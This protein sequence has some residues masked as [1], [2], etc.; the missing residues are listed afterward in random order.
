MSQL[1]QVRGSF[2][3]ISEFNP[4]RPATRAEIIKLNVHQKTAFQL[5]S[6]DRKAEAL[7]WEV[8]INAV[9]RLQGIRGSVT[10]A[11]K[12]L[13]SRA[14]D[15]DLQPY[16]LQALKT[17]AVGKNSLPS[18]STIFEKIS[19]YREQ[20]LDGL[21][22]QHKGRIRQE[23][24]WEG[25]ALELYSLPSKPDFSAVHR[26]LVAMG[27]KC[28]YDQV[29]DYLKALPATLGAMSP[30]RIGRD[31]YRQTEAKYIERC[32]D[33]LLPGDIYMADGYRADVYLAHPVTGDIWR[34]E[35]MHV[36]DLR[37]RVLVGYRIMAHEGSYD[38]MFG[39]AEIF[40]RW[41]HVP[42]LLYVDNGSGY[43]NRL[44]ELE[45]VSYYQRAGIQQV[46]HSIPRNPRG[47]GH[48]ERY[49]RTVKDRHL[50]LWRPEC[51]CGDD[52]A[53]EVLQQTVRDA[54][55]GRL[56]LP[57]VQ[58]FIAAYD[59]WI[60]EY[61]HDVHPEDKNLI[62]WDLWMQL[63][64]IPPHATVA[65]IARPAEKRTVL[66]GAVQ[67]NNRRYRCPDLIMWNH[68]EVMV[69]CDVL[70]DKTV[71]IRTLKGE[72]I[73]SANLV[74]KIGM[75]SDSLLQ[76]KRNAAEKAAIKRK[77]KQIAEIEARNGFVIDVDAITE[78]LL[79]ETIDVTPEP[80]NNTSIEIDLND[81]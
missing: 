81:I 63:Q 78:I 9:Q 29:K 57:T 2:V 7:Q 45:D 48:V 12:L 55:S 37:S 38:I 50:K 54:K 10:T 1:K 74:E 31:L 69:E 46:I 15:N 20:G 4:P 68:Q 27:L 33:N 39:W 51:Y 5:A 60:E 80:T 43:K 73:C 79:P 64:P 23:L 76:D 36:L 44:T 62:K 49:H 22:K 70:N 56:Q 21:I 19:A 17:V 41:N 53:P 24:G 18:R 58:E 30:A 65:Q 61:N 52:M 28:S 59:K 8:V 77:Q 25:F 13:L 66:K 72:F 16:V 26:R 32:T 42:P 47:K 11:V 71:D 35:I 34:P 67:I 6:D 75:L 40:T 3:S 14:Q